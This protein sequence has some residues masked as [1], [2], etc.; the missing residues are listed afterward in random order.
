MTAPTRT[1]ELAR[2]ALARA[3]SARVTWHAETDWPDH[4]GS[5][6]LDRPDAATE[7]DRLPA[8]VEVA[9]PAPL[10]VRDRIRTRVLL[11]GLAAP[12]PGRPGGI[13]LKPVGVEL[14]AAGTRTAVTPAE[15]RAA[16]PDPLTHHEATYLSHL[17]QAH[18]DVV[19]ALAARAFPSA[20]PGRVVP[21]ALDRHGL[22]L[23]A[24]TGARTSPGQGA[25]HR[26]VRLD[27]GA[28][29]TCPEQVRE[30]MLRLLEQ[31]STKPGLLAALLGAG[32]AAARICRP[33]G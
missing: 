20:R 14:V 31:P 21:L 27:F 10:P 3:A 32:P 23:R 4:A 7:G 11:H 18:P 12:Q 29:V 24:E 13:R 2:S 6:V 16:R 28:P 9:D 33:A 8:V 26:D 5:I 1:A 17:A 30:A 19:C 25:G 15:L 22:T